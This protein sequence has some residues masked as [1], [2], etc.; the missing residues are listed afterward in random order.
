MTA[1]TYFMGDLAEYT[2]YSQVLFGTRFYEVLLLEGHLEG[3]KR[4]VKNPPKS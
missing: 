1:Q 4:L 2:G 3:E